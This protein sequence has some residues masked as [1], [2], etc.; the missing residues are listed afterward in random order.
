[1]NDPALFTFLNRLL[2][3]TWQKDAQTFCDFSWCENL[4]FQPFKF[5][6]LTAKSG[7]NKKV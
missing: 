5:T 3:Y 4:K 2:G 1:M 6:V 7:Y